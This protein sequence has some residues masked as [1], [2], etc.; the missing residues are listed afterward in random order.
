MPANRLGDTPVGNKKIVPATR[1][2]A[3]PPKATGNPFDLSTD[4][5]VPKALGVIHA[6]EQAGNLTATDKKLFN[7]LLAVAYPD[8]MTRELHTVPIAD[9][10][11]CLGSHESN[12]RVRASATRLAEVVLK[13]DYLDADG[14]ERWTAGPLLWVDGPKYEGVLRFQFP[15]MLKPLLAEPALFARLRLAVLGQFRSKYAITLYELLEIYANRERPVWGVATEDL[16]ALL[17]VGDKM[18]NFKDFRSR[19]LDPAVSEVNDKSDLTVSFE[20][21]KDGRRVARVVFRVEKKD[22]RQAFEAE[23]RH[24]SVKERL[25][26]R[27]HLRDGKTPD[28]LDGRT[29]N[30]RGGPPFL[31]VSTIDEARRQFPGMDIE[32]LEREWMR[33]QEGREAPRDPDRA[34]IGWVGVQVRKLA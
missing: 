7:W 2:K 9:V 22:A 16:R 31:K 13:Y 30:E 27:R 20:E 18:K 28:L 33:Q 10:R 32:Y 26:R 6:S 15:A 29:D 4:P 14:N 21:E 1:A 19:V 25:P 34:F 5:T 11:V 17:S 23:L 3:P 24:K 8:L 12:D